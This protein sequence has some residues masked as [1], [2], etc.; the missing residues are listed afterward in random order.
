MVPVQV[1]QFCFRILRRRRLQEL[2]DRATR[3][4]VT[5]LCAPAGAGKT[6][7]CTAWGTARARTQQI[8]WVTLESQD[9]QAWFWA[10]VCAGLKQIQAVPRE[11]GRS[12]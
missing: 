9:D 11:V 5:L 4:R 12:H 3:R 8:V 10:R 7:A 2:I 6:V 1:P